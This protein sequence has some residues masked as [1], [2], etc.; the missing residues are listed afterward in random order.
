MLAYHDLPWPTLVYHGIFKT[1]QAK[2]ILR[3]AQV[4]IHQFFTLLHS[5]HLFFEALLM[6]VINGLLY[7]FLPHLLHGHV[8]EAN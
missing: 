4:I 1:F 6:V 8:R 5:Y 2:I 7:L 3:F